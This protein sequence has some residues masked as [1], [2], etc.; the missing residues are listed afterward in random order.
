MSISNRGLV[1]LLLGPTLLS[2]LPAGL[3]AAAVAKNQYGMKIEK[4][5]SVAISARGH[6][7]HFRPHFSI[8]VSDTDPALK[9]TRDSETAYDV[10]S[11]LPAP[12]GGRT[13]D[14]FGAGEV[15]SIDAAHAEVEA[16]TVRWTFPEQSR[17]R[18][19][20]KLVMA[21][22]GQ[23]PVIEFQ[24]TALEPGWYSIGY[25]GFPEL[26]KSAITRLW[27]PLVWQERRFPSHSFLSMEFMCSLPAVFV[28]SKDDTI[29]L[30]V[31]PSEVPFRLPTM[32][33]SR[34]GVALRN[35]EGRAQ[36]M[37]F[38][39]VFGL[40]DSHFKPGATA[41]FRF[42]IFVRDGSWFDTYRHVAQDIF[43]F[44]D[45]RYNG[46]ASLNTTLDNMIDFAMNDTY[47]G[48]VQDLK[49]F[50]YTTDVPGTVKLVSALHPLSVAII[51][52][53]P[54]IYRRRALPMIEYIM[55]RQKYLYSVSDT[56][57]GQNASHLMKGPCAE[58]SELSALYSMSLN[59]SPV[60]SYYADLLSKTPRRLNLN[61]VS[62]GDSFQDML[63]LY[64]MTDNDSY[65]DKAKAKALLYITQRI[66]QTQEDFKDVHVETGGQFWTDFAPKWIDLLELYESTQDTRF[67]N[68][69]EDGAKE[70]AQYI[71][72][73]P[74]VPNR[75]VLVN[76]G[77]KTIVSSSP[78]RM[79][80][81][82]PEPIPA[83]EEM[84]P[85]WRVS[86]IGL[87]PEASTTYAYNP[88]VLLT[89]YAAY[90]LRL[91]YYTGDTFLRDIARSAVVGRYE[92][93][94][95]YDIKG[96]FTTTYQHPDYPLRPWNQLTYNMI[97]YN[98]VW[99]NIAL[100]YD[101]LI[102]DAL[103]R[104]QGKVAFPSQYAQ[105]YAYLQS[106]V[107]GDRPGEVYGERGVRLWMPGKLVE[108]DQT[109]VNY[110]AGYGSNALYLIFMNQSQSNLQVHLRLDPNIVPLDINRN[111]KVRVWI[112]NRASGRMQLAQGQLTVPVS[113]KGI[114]ALAID[115]LR[116]E[117]HFQS[118][119]LD[120]EARP[121]SDQS[122]RTIAS[123]FGPVTGMLLSMGR[124][125]N[126]AYIWLE[127]TEKDLTEAR[128]SYKED[129]QWKKIVD[130]HYPYEFSLPFSDTDP[131]FEF[132]VEGVKP[133]GS[134]VRSS[135]VDLH[136]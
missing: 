97:Y 125:L 130:S 63:A 106:K 6:T 42:R 64:R 24:F 91:S 109:E 31:D 111:Y 120:T 12:S 88:A 3:S 118:E 9:L 62:K 83:P 15:V 35:P 136:R 18:L 41:R 39:P 116:I 46:P 61:M 21:P 81:H 113:T 28:Q 13:T 84:V 127:A 80:K 43:G 10:P 22:A 49:A 82:D 107:Y 27:Q 38:S 30:S 2:L 33:N 74:A 47:S 37:V 110:L 105:G 69:A 76:K 58:V 93:F 89:H 104:S 108:S 45:Y 4:D 14:L 8:L 36:P 7:A 135:Q 23:D 99:P 1:R 115:G 86:Q 98:Q 34:F 102:S 26:E 57:T 72:L 77:S 100:L 71:W 132:Y 129:G 119:Y 96:E 32:K 122:Y 66:D 51:R 131:N 19:Q 123:P 70:F 44:H 25:T 90:M 101:Y 68:A 114:S 52:D 126:S 65:L 112:D 75:D 79:V 60:F 134:V 56:I 103:A 117:P 133:D 73:D 40:E 87:T 54:E 59:R 78:T 121:L 17:F 50:D 11:W 67:L 95:G 124:S 92:N 48:W 128:L 16:E 5:G 55:S 29:G 94:P 85:A 20:A 53:D